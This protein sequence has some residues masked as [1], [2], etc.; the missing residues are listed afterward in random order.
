[1][2]SRSELSLST[3]RRIIDVIHTEWFN[4]GSF[5]IREVAAAADVSISSVLRTLHILRQI[6]LIS[7]SERAFAGRHY[8]V[9]NNWPQTMKEAIDAFEYA[10]ILR[11]I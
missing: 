9:N 4:G 7:Y 3:H 5:A 1:M 11:M 6:R 10:K 8:R 2:T